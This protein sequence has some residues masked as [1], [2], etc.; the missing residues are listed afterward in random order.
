MELGNRKG[1]CTLWWY[2][3]G[4]L[5]WVLGETAQELGPAGGKTSRLMAAMADSVP[6]ERGMTTVGEGLR[7]A[8]VPCF[9][10]SETDGCRA[11][12]ESFL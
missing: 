12:Q 1:E 10:W 11:N 6:R 7:Y 2:F 8:A 4:S 5:S 9:S 3:L